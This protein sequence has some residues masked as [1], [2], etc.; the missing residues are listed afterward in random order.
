MARSSTDFLSTHHTIAL[1]GNPNVGKST[2]F[3]GLTGLK[4]HTGNWPGKTVTY[5]KGHYTYKNDSYTLID[6]PGTYSLITHSKEEEVTRD[7]VYLEHPDAI[8]VVCDA[9]CLER[10]LIL[11]LQ[12]RELSDHVIVCVNLLDEAQ[13]KGIHVDCAKLAT[14]L[15]IPVIG[16]CARDLKGLQELLEAAYLQIH[17]PP[18]LAPNHLTYP[19][20]LSEALEQLISRLSRYPTLTFSSNFLALKLLENDASFID[21]LKH[22]TPEVQLSDAEYV[23]FLTDAAEIRRAYHLTPH[24]LQDMVVATYIKHAEKLAQQVCTLSPNPHDKRDTKLDALLMGRYTSFPIMLILL[25]FIL[26][27]TIVGSN[28]PSDLLFSAFAALEP[29][30]KQLLVTLHIPQFL[31]SASIDGIY[32]VLTWVISVMFPPMAI[33]FPLFTLLEDF[34]YLPRIAFNLDYPFKKCH[35]CG[36]QALTMCMGLGCNAVGVEGCRIIDSPRERLIALL[37]NSFMP[38][39]G[40]FPTLILLINLFFVTQQATILH[41]ILCTFYL[42][43]ALLLSL[44]LTFFTSWLLSKTILK[45]FPSSFTL[46]LPPYRKPKIMQTLVRSLLD[47][48]L[49]VLKRAILVSAPAGL[50]IWLLANLSIHQTTCLSY[51]IG[52]LDPLARQFGLDGVILAAFILGLPANEMILPIIIMCYMASNSVLPLSHGSQIQTLLLSQGWTPFTAICTF[53]FLLIHWPCSTTL[54]TIYK[55]TQSIK[56]T[57]IAFVLPTLCG[58]CLCFIIAHLAPFF[59]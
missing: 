49:Y 6:L 9:S 53:I 52:F 47:R 5:A 33:F 11:A 39:N 24:T 44:V 38:C 18:H 23:H 15:G 43:L 27:L 8:I 35:A 59:I 28:Y 56:W 57:L 14:L 55:E 31:I 2:V 19:S 21:F 51:V 20:P 7:F 46:E 58:L 34:G 16:T 32:R 3:N 10:N 22:S 41:S 25:A 50:M 54:L 36:K 4:Q 13:K 26:W 42:L 12:V 17:H 37:T 1:V 45:G 30:L 29:L 48:T 40:R